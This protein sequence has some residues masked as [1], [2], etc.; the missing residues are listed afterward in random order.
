MSTP[1]N[2]QLVNRGIA[3]L[4]GVPLGGFLKQSCIDY[5]GMISAVLYTAGCNLRCIY[6]HNPELVL[7]DRIQRL[8]AEERETI[9]TWLVRNRML[10]DAVV[11]TGGEPLLHPALPGLLGWIR[12]LG[13]AV[14]L[15]TN[16]TFPSRLQAILTEELVDHVA[17]DLKAP[18][19]YTKY[20]VICGRV[21]SHD[22]LHAIRRSL[23]LLRERQGESEIRTTLLKPYHLP[24][25]I[26]S[27]LDEAGQLWRSQTFR[28][29]KTL[30]HIEAESYTVQEISCLTR[31][32]RTK[33]ERALLL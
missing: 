29:E 6:C 11:V 25:D 32:W 10:L 14:K 8:G 24:E 5:P 18:L 4:E 33:E 31:V 12:E 20:S 15:D 30:Q 23:C 17:M 1:G 19:D 2:S 21:F 22:M 26:F 7:P 3:A 27:I 9:V 28:P 16:G 13:L